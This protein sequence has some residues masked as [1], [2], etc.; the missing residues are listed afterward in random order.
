VTLRAN[1]ARNR[2]EAK[3]GGLLPMQDFPYGTRRV[4]IYGKTAQP[5]YE[6]VPLTL[7]DFLNPQPDDDFNQGDAH[8]EQVRWCRGLFRR[9][10]RFNPNLNV[11]SYVQMR[12]RDEALARPIADIA[13]VPH[14]EEPGRPRMVFDEA[15]EGTSPTFI[16]EVTSPLFARLDL[17]DK[18]EVYRRAGVREYFVLDMGAG[19]SPA[20]LVGYERQDDAYA[21]L[22]PDEHGRL[23]SK[24][25]RAWLSITPDGSR[26]RIHV[27]RTGAEVVPDADDLD[28]SSFSDQ[29]EGTFRAQSIASQLGL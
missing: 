1:G 8:W 2:I 3:Q 18:V 21:P 24:V 28:D 26:L 4:V 9:L 5:R 29:V 17:E 19:E 13:I 7:E 15:A 23:Y 20:R 16:L 22:A 11:L 6:D 12:W 10:H 14:L 27:A 25:N